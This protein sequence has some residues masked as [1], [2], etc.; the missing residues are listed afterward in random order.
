MLNVLAD[1][2][3]RLQVAYLFISHDLSVIAHIADRVAVMY[4]GAIVEQGQVAEV[5]R[6]PYHPYTEALLSAIP[7]VGQG[8]GRERI[9]LRGDAVEKGVEAHGCRF[10]HRCP[11]KFGEVCEREAPPMVEASAG[12]RI[13]CH[14][15]LAPASG[16]SA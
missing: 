1:L 3:D 12:H 15:P 5:L 7:E 11:R 16:L 10:Q 9:R 4:R 6:P 13:A 8:S 2:R 14:I